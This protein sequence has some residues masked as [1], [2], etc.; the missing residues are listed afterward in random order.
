MLSSTAAR[1]KA[2]LE[3]ENIQTWIFSV[4]RNGHNLIFKKL[5]KGFKKLFG[6]AAR[7]SPGMLTVY[8]A[9]VA[10]KEGYWKDVICNGSGYELA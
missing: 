3:G 8:F 7:G 9:L 10:V 1:S 2:T 5:Y 4:V 6:V